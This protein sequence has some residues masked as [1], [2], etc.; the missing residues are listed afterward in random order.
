M[1]ALLQRFSVPQRGHAVIFVFHM[2]FP[3]DLCPGMFCSSQILVFFSSSWAYTSNIF[4]YQ[5]RGESAAQQ[6]VVVEGSCGDGPAECYHPR[7]FATPS[8]VWRAKMEHTWL[9][10][11]PVKAVRSRCCHP[12]TCRGWW[13][14]VDGAVSPAHCPVWVRARL[15]RAEVASQ[16][17]NEK[18]LW[19]PGRLCGSVWIWVWCHSAE[20][21]VCSIGFWS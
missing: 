10:W 4:V 16:R 11:C 7:V 2:K 21:M 17:C 18:I 15:L 19:V 14:A 1:E 3:E 20:A 13:A 12:L 8:I 6:S 9:K 5:S